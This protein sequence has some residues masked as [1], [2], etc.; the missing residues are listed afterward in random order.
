MSAPR[1]AVV[2]TAQVG[3]VRLEAM[4]FAIALEDAT[5]KGFESV[6]W[7]SFSPGEKYHFLRK[8]ILAYGAGE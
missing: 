6:T 4:A 8:A 5:P 7:D 1:P 2:I 3:L